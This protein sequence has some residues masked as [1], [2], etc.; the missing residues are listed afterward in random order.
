MIFTLL[1]TVCTSQEKEIAL[2]TLLLPLVHLVYQDSPHVHALQTSSQGPG[3]GPGQGQGQGVGG[4]GEYVTVLG[5][6]PGQMPDYWT[7]STTF[8]YGQEGGGS[9]STVTSVC[10]D[11]PHMVIKTPAK[12]PTELAKGK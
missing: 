4:T 11:T 5:L 9:N 10:S 8:H 7:P 1:C 12:Y 3:L 6:G 2:L